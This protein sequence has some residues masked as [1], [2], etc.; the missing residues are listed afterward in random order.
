MFVT[1]RDPAWSEVLTRCRHDVYHLPAYAGL[2]AQRLGGEAQAFLA[3]IDGAEVLLPVV[4]R[5]VPGAPGRSDLVSPYG[6]PGPVAT[7]PALL[8]RRAAWERLEDEL[9]RAMRAEGLVTAF[10]RLHPLLNDGVAGA[11]ERLDGLRLEGPTVSAS[12]RPDENL[13]ETELRLRDDHRRGVRKLRRLGFTTRLD[14]GSQLPAFEATY[15]ATMRRLGAA[16]EYFFDE[17]YF[18]ALR[19]GE[20]GR[21]THLISVHADDGAF[22]AG[23]LFF[24]R[25]GALQYHLSASVE[26]HLKLAPT[27]LAILEA[28]RW[29]IETGGSS[30]HLGGGLGARRDNLFRFKQGFCDRESIFAT[31]RV[32]A[33][34]D[35]YRRLGGADGDPRE[36][37]FPAYRAPRE[38]LDA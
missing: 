7:D 2:E 18:A 5:P 30:L 27:K 38:A 8:D 10:L 29:G 1:T 24:R 15:R 35:L 4:R 33:D 16:R 13:A 37:F 22:A 14:D 12:L 6:Y 9:R 19:E 25:C 36:G 20:L 11:A 21:C 17:A 31:L 23:A 28:M 26:A 3:S 34:P 32:V